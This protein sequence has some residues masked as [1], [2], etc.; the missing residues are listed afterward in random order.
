MCLMVVVDVVVCDVGKIVFV[1]DMVMGGDVEWLYEW[2]G[3]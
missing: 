2:V 1:F 3:W